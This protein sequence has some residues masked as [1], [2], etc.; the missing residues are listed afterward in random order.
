MKV[1][2]VAPRTN[3]LSVDSEIQDVIRSGL[4][5]TPLLGTVNSTDLLREIRIGDYDVLWLATHGDNDGILLS[6]GPFSASEL[7]PQVRDRFSLVVLNTCN[8]LLTAQLLQ[9]EANISV[10]CTLINVPDRQAYQTGSRLA[11]ALA[12]SDNIASAYRASRPGQNR[13]Y[14]FLAALQLSQVSID[15]LVKELRD[16]RAEMKHDHEVY[17]EDRRLRWRLIILSLAMQP[18][19]WVVC[20]LFWRFA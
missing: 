6:D 3:L 19:F 7:V 5:V 16:L 17:Q 8:S 15:A 11:S 10:I 20:W 13:S 12:E 9:E 1:L 14:L 4:S 18:V 2:L